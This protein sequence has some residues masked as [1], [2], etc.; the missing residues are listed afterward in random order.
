M[1]IL[2]AARR[3]MVL[4]GA[5]APPPAVAAVE[6]AGCAGA[7]RDV[8][9]EVR[10][11]AEAAFA[12]GL[13]EGIERGAAQ[14]AARAREIE[15][16][17]QDRY[18]AGLAALAADLLGRLDRELAQ[19]RDETA[20]AA[21]EVVRAWLGGG[22]LGEALDQLELELRRA[23]HDGAAAKASISGPQDLIDALH[24]RIA[25]LGT[26]VECAAAGAAEI[27]IRLDRQVIETRI[28]EWLQAIGGP[29]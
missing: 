25:D 19:I 17:A 6:P 28:G 12:R 16:R 11:A 8:D 20:S 14:L 22:I 10:V 3:L 15:M 4:G 5:D 9:E 26:S 29:S 27:R 13:A 7:P 18:E 23:L 1:A 21:A 24:M 2:P